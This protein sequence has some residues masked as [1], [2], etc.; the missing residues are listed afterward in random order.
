[1][2]LRVWQCWQLRR[3]LSSVTAR[4]AK[5]KVGGEVDA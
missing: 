2:A 5:L 3:K 4:V 1:V